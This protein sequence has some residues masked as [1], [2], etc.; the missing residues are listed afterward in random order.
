M[1]VQCRRLIMH[2]IPVVE[3]LI[4]DLVYRSPLFLLHAAKG[5]NLE[6]FIINLAIYRCYFHKFT[7]FIS[8]A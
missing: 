3:V 8:T 5:E 7:F 2:C 6:A 1:Y 4:A